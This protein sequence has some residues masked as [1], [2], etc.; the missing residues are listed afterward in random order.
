MT[1]RRCSEPVRQLRSGDNRPGARDRRFVLPAG[2]WR[3]RGKRRER[4]A[5]LGTVVGSSIA[6]ED[7]PQA[8][9]VRGWTVMASG[10]PS[11][12]F[13]FLRTRSSFWVTPARQQGNA[14]A[15]AGDGLAFAGSQ[16]A[17]PRLRRRWQRLRPACL[18]S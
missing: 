6:R 13:R 4:R 9:R 3:C 15:L 12:A 2:A 10:R 8:V 5:P 17:N 11:V 14:S 16:D 1:W 18:R 7:L